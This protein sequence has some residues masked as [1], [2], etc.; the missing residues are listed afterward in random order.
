MNMSTSPPR[1]S[2]VLGRRIGNWRAQQDSNGMDGATRVQWARR[3]IGATASVV[4]LSAACG[5]MGAGT[6]SAMPRDCKTYAAAMQYQLQWEDY[7]L[8]Q[9]ESAV[10]NSSWGE[11]HTDI[12][13][14]G[15]AIAGYNRVVGEAAAAG[16]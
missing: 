6:A 9:W 2:A 3:C 7:W 4:I 11:L 10:S 14:Y 8:G 5:L 1:F 15:S 13:E 16:C 12:R